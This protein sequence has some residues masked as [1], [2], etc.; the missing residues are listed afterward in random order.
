MYKIKKQVFIYAKKTR[1][2]RIKMADLN[3]FVVLLNDEQD[4]KDRF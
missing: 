4:R 2:Y 3:K 1:N